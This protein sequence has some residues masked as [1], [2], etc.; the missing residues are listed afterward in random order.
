MTTKKIA[1]GGFAAVPD[2]AFAE[3]STA[4]LVTGHS[5]QWLKAQPSKSVSIFFFSPPYNKRSRRKRRGHEGGTWGGAPLLVEGYAS[6]SDDLPHDEYVSWMH[7]LLNECWR[8]L[9]DD[10][11]I[12]FQHK[13]QPFKGR[14][15]TPEELIP[16]DVLDHLRQRIIW[17]RQAAYTPNKNFLNPSFEFIHLLAKPKFKFAT[18]GKLFDVLSIRPTAKIDPNHPAPMPVELPRRIFEHLKPEHDIICDPFSGSG[19]TGVAARATGRHYIGIELDAGYNAK[20]AK[21]LNCTVETLAPPAPV[22]RPAVKATLFNADC[23]KAMTKLPDESVH[24]IAVDLPYGVSVEVWDKIVPLDKM[25]AEFRRIL[26]PTG[27]IVLTAQGRFTNALMN[28]ALDLHRFNMVWAKTR[29][30]QHL[31]KDY[32]VLAEHED[33]LVFAKGGMGNNAKVHPTYNPQGL[34]EL[35]TPITSRNGNQEDSFYKVRGLNADR[36]RY[37]THTNWPSSILFFPSVGGKEKIK[38]KGNA[39]QTQK[40]V[41]LMD[42][43]I[44]TYSNE[45]ETVLDCTMGSGTTGVAALQAGRNFIGMEINPR[46]FE[47]TEVRIRAAAPDAEFETHVE[48]APVEAPIKSMIDEMMERKRAAYREFKAREAA[49]KSAKSNVVTLTA[50]CRVEREQPVFVIDDLCDM[51]IAA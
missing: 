50:A 48:S 1:R 49:V 8:V 15:L 39:P 14:L 22:E 32:R 19:T 37:Q 31:H 40:P 18:A 20:A 43:L 44:R 27:N 28:A 26:T 10:G 16:A 2:P 7:D 4:R 47:N 42:Y 6:F 9:K 17:H 46:F 51:L 3:G 25:F 13:D 23:L 45:G 36:G 35:E 30:T 12:F 38:G 11:A 29:K 33:V 21:R 41:A 24:L 34:V 5:L